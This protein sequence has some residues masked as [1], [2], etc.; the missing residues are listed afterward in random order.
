MVVM[1][2]YTDSTGNAAANQKLSM[3]RAY[4]VQ[5]FLQ[6]TGGLAPG[7]ANAPDGMGVATDA[8]TGSNANARK[9]TVKLVVDKGVWTSRCGGR[10]T[11]T[12]S[13]NGRRS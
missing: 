1:Q 11:P 5:N 2:G 7:R 4:A 6:Q 13:S 10:S 9:V 8:G 3:Q 12:A